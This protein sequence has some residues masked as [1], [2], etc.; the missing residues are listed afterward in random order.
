MSK[1]FENK[2]DSEGSVEE[3]T[4]EELRLLD[5]YHEQT[6]HIFSVRVYFI[7]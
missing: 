2:Y 6:K 5:K 3:Y 7:L 1:L 4:A